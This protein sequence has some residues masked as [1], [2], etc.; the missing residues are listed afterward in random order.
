[1][2]IYNCSF[3]VRNIIHTYDKCCGIAVVPE[4]GEQGIRSKEQGFILV[5]CY[6]LPVVSK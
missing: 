4:K 6:Q 1:M 3:I 2:G 5:T